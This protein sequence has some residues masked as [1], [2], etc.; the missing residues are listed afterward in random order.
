M[1][2]LVFFI[3]FIL[4]FCLGYSATSYALITTKNEVSWLPASNGGASREYYLARGDDNNSTGL[5]TWN[6]LRNAL[7][8]GMW[9]IYGQVDLINHD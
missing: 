2:N 4:I 7:E 5:W 3:C 8:W 1:M 6:T 9:K